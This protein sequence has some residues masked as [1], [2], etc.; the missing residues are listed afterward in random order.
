MGEMKG[1]EAVIRGLEAHD[2]EHVFGVCGD[3]SVGLYR[4]LSEL[5]H[6]IEHILARDERS[7]AFMADAYARTSNRPGVCEA[8]SG[9]GAT[10][11]VPGLAEATDSAVPVVALN[12]DIPVKYRNRGVLTEIDQTTFFD[13]VTKWNASVDH[14][15]LLPRLLRQAFRRATVGR[16]G[17]THLSLP[18]DVLDQTTDEPTYGDPEA[19][20]CP[21]FRP[22]PDP[23]RIAEAAERLEESDRPVIV[24]GGGV[25][26]SGAWL[27]VQQLAEKAGIPVAQT[28]TGC[29]CIGDSPYSIGVVGENGY[30][31]YAN[32]I[33]AEADTLLLLGT[34][35]ESVWT[36]KWS[37]PPDQTTTVIHVDVDAE[38][39]GLNYETEVAV[40]GDLRRAV[41]VLHTHLSEGEAWAADD[42]AD[43]HA[44]WIERFRD[45]MRSDA[46]PIRPE[47]MVADAR[48][49][50]PD[51]AIIVS[52]PG[53]SCPYFAALYP[54]PRPGRHWLTPR[55][56]GALGYAIP[57]VVGA[58]F[59]RPTAPIVGFT[60]DG[61]FGTSVGELETIAR[62]SLP[63]TIVLVRN[64][65]FSWIEAGQRNYADFS[66]GVSFDATDYA[67]IAEDFGMT[68]YRVTSAENYAD[69]LMEAVN[70]DGPA[71]IDLPCMPLTDVEDP[72]VDWLEPSA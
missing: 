61:S 29:G 68:G 6:H 42:L 54:F 62:Y 51:D 69:V 59:A 36:K 50:L 7:A 65:A 26:T 35:V 38:R 56:H 9:G 5:D 28:L 63:V 46:F 19:T 45:G 22:D 40:P 10:Y 71:L 12:T 34:A 37:Q 72:P 1:S 39:I 41:K 4:S 11:L 20:R 13:P 57:G 31:D 47:R 3:T 49:V 18:M 32:D 66:F 55:A 17:A 27:T 21:A 48:S 70:L 14:P 67:G 23:D 2:V 33:V 52:D 16:P 24:A 64:D 53:T 30:R 43:L 15:D 8:P 60:G 58:H 44:D 25:H